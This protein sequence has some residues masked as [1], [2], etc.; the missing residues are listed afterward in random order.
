MQTA[1]WPIV[2]ILFSVYHGGLFVIGDL[3]HNVSST[4]IDNWHAGFWFRGWLWS[5]RVRLR[6]SPLACTLAR[7]GRFRASEEII[8]ENTPSQ[9]CP[10]FRPLADRGVFFYPPPHHQLLGYVCSFRASAPCS[11]GLSWTFIS[12]HTGLVLMN[13]DRP[14]FTDRL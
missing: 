12:H 4:L 2:S 5:Y 3:G 7:A 9:A 8:F 1:F 14:Q 13:T 10:P 6:D 11:E